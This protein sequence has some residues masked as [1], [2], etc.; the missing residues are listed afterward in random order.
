MDPFPA[1][2]SSYLLA[3][4]RR[5]RFFFKSYEKRDPLIPNSDDKAGNKIYSIERKHRYTGIKYKNCYYNI[6]IIYR[7]IE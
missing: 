4:L 1:F 3:F 2:S 7:V 5:P 6:F